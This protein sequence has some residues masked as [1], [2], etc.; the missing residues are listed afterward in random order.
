MN[1]TTGLLALPGIAFIT[2]SV[3]IHWR[4]KIDQFERSLY[5]EHE[6]LRNDLDKL[7]DE[8]GFGQEY[9]AV[10]VSRKEKC[11]GD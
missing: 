8:F 11:F 4:L 7:K 1:K 5:L 10:T 2:V 3:Y 6:K 9:L